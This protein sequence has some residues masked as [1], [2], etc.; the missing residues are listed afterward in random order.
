MFQQWDV[1]ASKSSLLCVLLQS[2]SNAKLSLLPKFISHSLKS[3][4]IVS[5]APVSKFHL[6]H[7]IAFFLSHLFQLLKHGM[8]LC[9]WETFFSVWSTTHVAFQIIKVDV[10]PST[11][12]DINQFDA[13]ALTNKSSDIPGLTSHRLTTFPGSWFDN[14][15]MICGVRHMKTMVLTYRHTGNAAVMTTELKSGKG[16]FHKGSSTWTDENLPLDKKAYHN[17]FTTFELEA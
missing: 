11:R 9:K 17:T 8:T 5:K 13:C 12:T 16:T 10:T 14:L 7:F 15:K 6:P 3:L 2:W 1:Q 4:Q